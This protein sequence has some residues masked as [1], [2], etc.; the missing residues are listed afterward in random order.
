MNCATFCFYYPRHLLTPTPTTHDFYLLPTTHDILLYSIKGKIVY[1][2]EG[3]EDQMRPKGPTKREETA[4]APALAPHSAEIVSFT[5]LF[6]GATLDI[7]SVRLVSNQ[8]FC[9]RLGAAILTRW[10]RN[11]LRS[12]D[13]FFFWHSSRPQS[14]MHDLH[15][16]PWPWKK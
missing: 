1:W 9:F 14:T 8:G 4:P 7:V 11:N 6:K 2:G 3:P 16:S 10:T 5:F 15:F 12:R 13:F